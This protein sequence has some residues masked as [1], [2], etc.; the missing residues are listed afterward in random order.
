M[1]LAACSGSSTPS[2]A[3]T[4]PAASLPT[5]SSAAASL[6][7]TSAG[8][9]V[10]ISFQA[11]PDQITPAAFW[12]DLVDKFNAA[13]P[14]VHVN[15][16][17]S[18]GSSQR[19]QFAATLLQAGTFPDVAWQLNVNQFHDAL[20]PYDVNDPIN[21]QQLGLQNM[22]WG[23]QMLNT[24][25]SS[26]SWTNIFYNKK[27]F[28]DAGITA[29]PKTWPEFEVVLQ[30]LKAAGDTPIVLGGEFIPAFYLIASFGNVFQESLDQCWYGKRHA[31]T[32]HFTDQGFVDSATR[33][34]DWL[35]QGY[36]SNGG[37]GN[38]YAQAGAA[39]LQ[40]KAA[41]YG[42]GSFETGSFKTN[43]PNGFDIGHFS[44]PSTD[45]KIHLAGNIG[46]GG[47]TV[48]K[49]T[50]YPAQ[51]TRFAQ[52]MSFDPQSLN[53]LYEVYGYAANVQ[54]TSGTIAP[55][56]TPIQ[57]EIVDE[58]NDP[59]NTKIVSYFG[60][61][62]VCGTVPGLNQELI[63]DAT[64]IFLGDDIHTSLAKMDA[65]WEAHK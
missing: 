37:L 29:T 1:V 49:T 44:T 58:L 14:D 38:S 20:L 8:G 41:M 42:M 33:I 5:G 3:T 24:A 63:T 11:D 7:A 15:F 51:A 52:F 46:S 22:L 31:D 32:V 45:G 2:N 65:Y 34:Q 53:K 13:N 23:G 35:K 26:E 40:G 10:E 56:Y 25:P 27:M 61:G 28:A 21:K 36:F 6:P 64:A 4:A 54:L 55:D 48:S 47:L 16:N 43:P 9:V 57:K 17:P 12:Q 39:F 50:K 18:P 62:D 19:D 59:A 60:A 30:K